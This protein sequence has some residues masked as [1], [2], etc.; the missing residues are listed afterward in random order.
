MVALAVTAALGPLA[1]APAHS[2]SRAGDRPAV[3]FDDVRASAEATPGGTEVSTTFRVRNRSEQRRAARTAYLSLVALDRDPGPQ[4]AYRLDAVRVPALA[5]GDTR[6][7]LSE[8]TA[9]R[10][11]VDGQYYVRVCSTSV[12]AHRTCTL[13]PTPSVLIGEAD[14]E[15]DTSDIYVGDVAPGS[16]T[17]AD[18]VVSNT[19]QSRT[20]RIR[21]AVRGGDHPGDFYVEDGTCTTWLA[22]GESCTAQVFFAPPEGARSIRNSWLL[23]RGSGRGGV[24]EA[25]L[26]ATI[27]APANG[28]SIAPAHHNYGTVAQG[29]S[30]S[31]TFTLTNDTD[32]DSTIISGQVDSQVDF[33]FDFSGDFTCDDG[34]A[35]PAGGSCTVTVVFAPSAADSDFAAGFTLYG[36]FGEEYASLAGNSHAPVTGPALRDPDLADSFR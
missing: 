26:G 3:V 27:M 1:T 4:R 12:P 31:H 15:L 13:S 10:A 29:E 20:N 18:V 6:S 33:Y 11:V 28:V 21:L 32:V 14:V 22:A 9:R 16:V 2:S 30:A 19:G 35:L 24:D 25:S 17:P 7:V 5:A 36:D 8:T 34:V 23:A